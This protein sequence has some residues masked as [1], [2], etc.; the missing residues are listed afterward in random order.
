MMQKKFRDQLA[1]GCALAP[2][3]HVLMA[4]SGGADSVAM[5]CLFA[6]VR[7]E[8]SLSL[9]CAHVEHGIRG[10][11]SLADCAFVRAL[12]EKKRIPFYTCSV[13]APAYAKENGCGLEEAARALRYDFLERTADEI[14]AA[15]I[16]LAH[17][18]GDQAETVLMRAARGSDIRGLCAIRLRRDRFIRPLLGADPQEL[19][20]YLMS[21]GQPWRED[22]TNADAI[23]TRNRLR[24]VVLP[25]LEAALPGAG[26]ALCRLARAAQRDEDFFAQQLDAL[27]IPVIPLVD[28]AAFDK[29]RL[30]CLHPALLSRFLV[31]AVEQAGIQPQSADVIGA[32]M[33]A[34]SQEEAVV[35]LTGG[36]HA[37]I[38]K[39]YVCLTRQ[40]AA[41]IDVPLRVP[42][43]TE[44]PFGR[45]LVRRAQEE[46]NG[47]GRREQAIPEALLK[48]AH[49]TGRRA[50]DAMVPFGMHT[51]VKL[52]KLMIDA[53][54]ERAM[55]KSVPVLR[56]DDRILF[57]AG[58]RPDECV[59]STQKQQRMIV[60][61]E[62]MLPGAEEE[63]DNRKENHHD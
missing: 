9:S 17:H 4:V 61:F 7:E 8:L 14:G 27:D 22:A 36:A 5:L 60:R 33:E 34:L 55:R 44:T 6:S 50:G 3:S 19:R 31:R 24:H 16:A 26:D 18:A 45:V 2:G 13:D 20:A 1:A 10:G 12:C 43:L 15:A 51:K 53:G 47:D 63:Q 58:L 21:I 54:I 48:G 37:Q 11:D 35:N 57:A 32:I 39:R 52:K 49:V 46:E 29:R 28:G 62:G 41:D 40:E 30:A 38:G 42:G 23:Y 59:R 56:S 25:Q